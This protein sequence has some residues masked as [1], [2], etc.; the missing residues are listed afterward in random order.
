[1]WWQGHMHLI[2]GSFHPTGILKQGRQ[3]SAVDTFL[4]FIASSLRVWL[5]QSDLEAL[6]FLPVPA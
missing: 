2:L 5:T 4:T 6:T 1:M 3:T